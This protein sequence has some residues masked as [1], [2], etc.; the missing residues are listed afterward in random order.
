MTSLNWKNKLLNNL[1][2]EVKFLAIQTNPTVILIN[3]TTI[4]I[5]VITPI[6]VLT[7]IKD[8]I[9][10]RPTILTKDTIRIK[11]ITLIKDIIALLRALDKISLIMLT[12]IL[13]K[14]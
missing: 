8:I 11:G 6:K 14:M 13:I 3:L 4:P 1:N 12:M 9:L 2:M 5:K 7:L 10:T